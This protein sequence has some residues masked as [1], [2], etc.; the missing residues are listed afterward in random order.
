MA[1]RHMENLGAAVWRTRKERD[2]SRSELGQLVGASE[3]TVERWEKG[4]HG[5]LMEALEPVARHLG[6]SPDGLMALAVEIGQERGNGEPAIQPE[7]R[8]GRLEEQME[9]LLEMMEKRTVS[10]AEDALSKDAKKKRPPK[11]G[12]DG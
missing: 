11:E 3:K 5:G 12:Q 9:K 6:T 1:E 2:L 4:T 10:E 8:I 7:D